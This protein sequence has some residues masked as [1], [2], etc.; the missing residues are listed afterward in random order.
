MPDDLELKIRGYAEA[1]DAETPSASELAPTDRA[2]TPH[3][4]ARHER[5]PAP[6]IGVAS[7]AAVVALILIP[8]W[9]LGTLSDSQPTDETPVA[10]PLEL[11]QLA[12]TPISISE[13]GDRFD[14]ISG[15]GRPAAD[16][17]FNAVQ[18]FDDVPDRADGYAFRLLV[19][20]SAVAPVTVDSRPDPRNPGRNI[21]SW[22][23]EFPNGVADGTTLVAEWCAPV[24]DGCL[25]RSWTIARASLDGEWDDSRVEEGALDEGGPAC[26]VAWDDELD[27]RQVLGEWCHRESY[28]SDDGRWLLIQEARLSPEQRTRWEADGSPATFAT[29]CLVNAGFLTEVDGDSMFAETSTIQFFPG[30]ATLQRCSLLLPGERLNLLTWQGLDAGVAFHIGQGFGGLSGL[31]DYSFTLELNGEALAPTGRLENEDRITWLYSFENGL[32]PGDKLTGT[33]VSAA[34]DGSRMETSES[35]IIGR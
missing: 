23:F 15:E 12:Y 7:F 24:L 20:G 5:L 28:R 11:S 34:I 29:E 19:N 22:T 14:L 21:V 32:Q 18:G 35:V 26:S 33:W 2:L 8:I 30:G 27:Q 17:P 3:P 10:S 13:V 31:V 6:L 25:D 4:V 16:E 9:L 1:L